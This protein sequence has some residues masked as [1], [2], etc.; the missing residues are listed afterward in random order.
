L[1][2]FFALLVVI[3][4]ALLVIVGWSQYREN[5]KFHETKLRFLTE[6]THDLT[7]R[8]LL[9]YEQ[10]ID[11]IGLQVRHGDTA[12]LPTIFDRLIATNPVLAGIAVSRPDGTVTIV[13]SNNDTS[14]LPNLRRQPQSRATFLEAL[15]SDHMVPG[16][17]YYLDAVGAWILPL[18]KA[19]RDEQGKPVAV[20][21]IGLKIDSSETVWNLQ[22]RP[23][24][25]LTLLL[26]GSW[27]PIYLSDARHPEKKEA[28]R[29]PLITPDR[30]QALKRAFLETY[31]LDLYRLRECEECVVLTYPPF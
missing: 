6:R 11:T 10:L 28:Y 2:T 25:W 19:I 22:N 14:K 5:L 27:Y 13:S 17:V 16:Q 24:A 8:F 31:G 20:V 4:T 29:H 21:S 9:Q 3:A 30:L 15:T 26:D 18:R 7:Y 23:D 1:W 12:S